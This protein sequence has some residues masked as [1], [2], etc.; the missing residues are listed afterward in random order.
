MNIFE[1]LERDEGFVP[2][3]YQDPLGY[4]TV[5]IGTCIDKR[6][7]GAR[8]TRDEA[9][10]LLDNR[11]RGFMAGLE[12][13][14]PWIRNLDDARYGVLQNMVYNLGV[15]GLLGFTTFLGHLE[16]GGHALAADA[17]LDSKWAR[18]VGARATRLAQQMRT[19]EWV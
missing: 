3:A 1:Q 6:V 18:Q 4:W 17:M 7:P 11:L 13:A 9:R 16:R 8:L 5:G 14:K 10:L 12:E 19:G 15:R 2:H